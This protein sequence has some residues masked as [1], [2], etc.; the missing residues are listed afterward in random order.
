M[1]K[2]KL[3]HFSNKNNLKSISPAFFGQNSYTRNDSNISN[4]KRFFCYDTENPAEYNFKNSFRYTLEIDKNLL[5][6][7]R[8]DR[9]GLISRF[10][11]IHDLLVY[12]SK[13]YLGAVYDVGFNCYII[14]K[15]IKTLTE[16]N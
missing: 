5:Y 11:D 3:Y 10:K 7:L 12:L 16:R 14:F 6:D 2:I 9:Q 15:E 13:N 1:D 8:E 4:V